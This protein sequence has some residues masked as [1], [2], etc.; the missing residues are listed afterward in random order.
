MVL[1]IFL[2]VRATA[3]SPPLGSVQRRCPAPTIA[4]LACGSGVVQAGLVAA[5]LVLGGGA[6]RVGEVGCGR[7]RVGLGNGLADVAVRLPV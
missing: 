4:R 3:S 1:V 7:S 6:C 5:T 2:L